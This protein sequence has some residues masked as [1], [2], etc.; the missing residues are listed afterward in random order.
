MAR[1]QELHWYLGIQNTPELN[2]PVL[3]RLN[4][5]TTF[6]AEKIPYRA[7]RI[8]A[9]NVLGNSLYIMWNQLRLPE[10]NDISET[11]IFTYNEIYDWAYL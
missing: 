7:L 1:Y 5:A 9:K 2:V 4:Q 10:Q 11:N 3:I 8:S 6:Y